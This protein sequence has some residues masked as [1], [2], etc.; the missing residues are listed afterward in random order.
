MFKE[1]C[2]FLTVIPAVFEVITRLYIILSIQNEYYLIQLPARINEYLLEKTRVIYQG[3][4][5]RNFH[6]FYL[7]FAGLSSDEFQRYGLESVEK[8]R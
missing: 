6:I 7:M 5:E 8:H 4:G 2:V 1:V 3:V